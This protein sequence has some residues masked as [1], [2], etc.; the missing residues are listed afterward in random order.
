MHIIEVTTCTPD[1]QHLHTVTDT[2]LGNHHDAQ[3]RAYE[4]AAA[5]T[6]DL[7]AQDPC[8]SHAHLITINDQPHTV[9]ATRS[10]NT[11]RINLLATLAELTQRH[12]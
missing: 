10:D 4:L 8:T 7:Y 3:H 2:G 1:G 6:I 5:V 11:N 9:I 12:T